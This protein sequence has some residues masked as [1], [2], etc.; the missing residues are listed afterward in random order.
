[1]LLWVR[2]TPHAE[3]SGRFRLSPGEVKSPR[4]EA[5][6]GHKH[7]CLYHRLIFLSRLREAGVLTTGL[8]IDFGIGVRNRANTLARITTQ[9]SNRR[10]NSKKRKP[11][12]SQT[13]TSSLLVP[14]VSVWVR[15]W[16][17]RRHFF[18]LRHESDANI[19]EYWYANVV[20]SGRT[21]MFQWIFEHMERN[22]RRWLHPR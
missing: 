4:S 17:N 11:V 1:M 22:R 16:W 8:V 19:R 12:I 7:G 21:N 6:D 5:G 3:R 15:S 18:P 20:L 10:Q 9:C 14:K 2:R 13:E